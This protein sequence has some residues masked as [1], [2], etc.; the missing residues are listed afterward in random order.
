MRL[1]LTRW[2]TA[3]V[4]SALSV[5][6]AFSSPVQ[7][8]Y[9]PPSQAGSLTAE[10]SAFLA[11]FNQWNANHNDLPVQFLQTT[12]A[13]DRGGAVVLLFWLWLQDSASM[14]S[15]GASLSS[16]SDPAGSTIGISGMIPAS[17]GSISS[18]LSKGSDD[19]PN[20]GSTLGSHNPPLQNGGPNGQHPGSDPFSG[21]DPPHVSGP[22]AP[23]ID[24]VPE[25][26]GFMLFCVGSFGLLL[27]SWLVTRKPINFISQAAC[28][29]GAVL[30]HTPR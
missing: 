5:I 29:S 6:I 25:P 23:S 15:N 21:G 17:L 28:R 4:A 16:P 18:L 24:P 2:M 8:G 22:P 27:G 9:T 26:A 19:L 1:D 7:A 30:P 11:D 10:A 20:G 13:H 14:L 3:A 12:P